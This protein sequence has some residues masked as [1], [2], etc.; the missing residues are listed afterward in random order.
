M[1]DFTT[2]VITARDY[3]SPLNKNIVD[4]LHSRDEDLRERMFYLE[5]PE[6]QEETTSYVV[7]D[8]WKLFIPPSAGQM[9]CAF[10]MHIQ[11]VTSGEARFNINSSALVSTVVSSSD[12][13]YS[14]APVFWCTFT[15]L[16]SVVD[17]E[18]TLEIETKITGTPAGGRW[19]RVREANGPVC[20]FLP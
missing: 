10:Q 7:H 17:T 19:V 20:Y 14:T 5:M 3:A 15:D 13:S 4:K 1:A 18:V 8:T 9:K 2:L 11:S 16:S 6:V 12:T